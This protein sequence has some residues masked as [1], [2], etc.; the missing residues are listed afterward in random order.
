MFKQTSVFPDQSRFRFG[1]CLVKPPVREIQEADAKAEAMGSV[2]R[3][4]KGFPRLPAKDKLKDGARGD[5]RREGSQSGSPVPNSDARG[6]GRRNRRRGLTVGRAKDG[7]QRQTTEA[8][9]LRR[10]L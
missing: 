4:Q 8:L 2:L 6:H 10:A 7:R 9:Y 1:P 3:V 5:V